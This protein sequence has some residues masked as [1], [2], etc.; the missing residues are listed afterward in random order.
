MRDEHR[1][2]LKALTERHLTPE[3]PLETALQRAR[4]V[5]NIIEKVHG[6]QLNTSI[7]KENLISCDYIL[8][9]VKKIK[10][11]LVKEAQWRP[12]FADM[13]RQGIKPRRRAGFLRH[14]LVESG[15]T[16][17]DVFDIFKV[18]SIKY[19]EYVRQWIIVCYMTGQERRWC[20]RLNQGEIERKKR[21]RHWRDDQAAKS[22]FDPTGKGGATREWTSWSPHS[23]RLCRQRTGEVSHQ[24]RG[25]QQW[26]IPDPSFRANHSDSSRSTLNFDVWFLHLLCWFFFLI[27]YWESDHVFEFFIFLSFKSFPKQ[28]NELIEL[29]SSREVVLVIVTVVKIADASTNYLPDM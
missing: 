10:E 15:I 26:N 14:L 13:F 19:D 25:K 21:S 22:S 11:D 23:L 27:I 18:V 1:M 9:Q 6:G 5:Y 16:Y 28:K 8:E 2:V 4:A 29:L 12:V 17:S 3:T 20:R 7:M 24:E